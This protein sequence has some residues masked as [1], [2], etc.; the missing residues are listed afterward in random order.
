MDW[1]ISS[2][3]YLEF[4]VLDWYQLHSYGRYL[5]SKTN[6]DGLSMEMS[7]ISPL[8]QEVGILSKIPHTDQLL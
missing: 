7:S 2:Y 6:G 5:V 1:I 3:I 4:G 8:S